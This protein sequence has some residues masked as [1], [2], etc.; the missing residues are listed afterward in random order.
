MLKPLVP[1][2]GIEEGQTVA[3]AGEEEEEEGP[4]DKVALLGALLRC[5]WH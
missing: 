4:Q 3:G 1:E 5:S 2:E